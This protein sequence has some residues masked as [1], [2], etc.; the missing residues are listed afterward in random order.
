EALDATDYDIYLGTSSP[1]TFKKN[2]SSNLYDRTTNLSAS[3]TYYWRIDANTPSGMVTGD[4]WSFTT[5]S[6]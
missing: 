5:G 2:Q 6:N 4:V 3:T 1:G